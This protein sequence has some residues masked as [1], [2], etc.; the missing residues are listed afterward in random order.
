MNDFSDA[1]MES[2]VE[3]VFEEEEAQPTQQPGWS[4]ADATLHATSD[5]SSLAFGTNSGDATVQQAS[6]DGAEGAA[7]LRRNRAG[8]SSKVQTQ[9]QPADR[10]RYVLAYA[11]PATPAATTEVAPVAEASTQLPFLVV[12]ASPVES[13]PP[14]H[15]NSSHAPPPLQLQNSNAIGPSSPPTDTT[16]PPH[17]HHHQRHDEDDAATTAALTPSLVRA[18]GR[19]ASCDPTVFHTAAPPTYQEYI[20]AEANGPVYGIPVLFAPAAQPPQQLR[21]APPAPGQQ[22]FDTPGPVDHGDL[23][24][25]P[26]EHAQYELLVK[27]RRLTVI[28]CI[29][30]TVVVGLLMTVVVW[31]GALAIFPICGCIGAYWIKLRLLAVYL[32][33][34]PLAIA[35]RAYVGYVTIT[36]SEQTDQ[37]QVFLVIMCVLGGLAEMYIAFA[38]VRCRRYM[39]AADDDQIAALRPTC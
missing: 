28:Y 1:E 30:D 32:A 34:F 17:H 35:A 22:Q 5:P 9:Q 20:A 29:A 4:G 2:D 39:V 36:S 11:A 19:M 26:P 27:A 10:R 25:V 21:G 6:D 38:V 37:G 24:A 7:I 23:I 33:Y 8:T 14:H 15:H 13:T 18:Y 3:I 12:V 16:L 31:L